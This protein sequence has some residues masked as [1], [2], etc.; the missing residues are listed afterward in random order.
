V[1]SQK[2]LLLCAGTQFGGAGGTGGD[3]GLG[4][5]GG[6]EGGGLQGKMEAGNLHMPL[7][8]VVQS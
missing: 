4:G 5:G 8:G 6:G 1:K 7:V 2:K 3:G